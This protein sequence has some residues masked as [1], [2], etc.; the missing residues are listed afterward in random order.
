M[1]YL[2]DAQ[3]HNIFIH[4][5]IIYIKPILCLSEIFVGCNRNSNFL[6]VVH[7]NNIYGN[8][9]LCSILQSYYHMEDTTC[10]I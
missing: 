4:T 9:I 2:A 1:L 6:I 10:K 7:L 8:L 3:Q 5:L